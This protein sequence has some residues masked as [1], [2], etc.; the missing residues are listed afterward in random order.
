MEAIRRWTGM[1]RPVILRRLNVAIATNSREELQVIA[2]MLRNESLDFIT[3]CINKLADA[4]KLD[5]IDNFST[6]LIGADAAN[7]K[8]VEALLKKDA[9]PN[10]TSEVGGIMP[11][12]IK[13]ILSDHYTKDTIYNL[14]TL[15]IKYGADIN[16]RYD[17]K[18]L[19]DYVYANLGRVSSKLLTFLTEKEAKMGILMRD[20]WAAANA[21]RA[22]AARDFGSSLIRSCCD[23]IL[24]DLFVARKNRRG[25][26]YGFPVVYM[27]KVVENMMSTEDELFFVYDRYSET[28]I[29]EVR[30]V[31]ILEDPR[32][33]QIKFKNPSDSSW[34]NFNYKTKVVS[35]GSRKTRNRRRASRK[36]KR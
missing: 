31:G 27:G 11:L 12:L 18:T 13:S 10:N 3:E 8:F 28:K 25:T 6:I 16:I 23:G 24:M 22:T 29:G 7:F 19:Q 15:L 32:D 34:K 5:Y 26:L 9:N 35:G 4:G 17:N 30:I 2:Q 21:E 14:I 20:Q 36:S 33:I 1:D